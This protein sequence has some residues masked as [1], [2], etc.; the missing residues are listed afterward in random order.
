MR[1]ALRVDVVQPT[2][3]LLKVVAADGG[4]ERPGVENVVEE[5]SSQD[6]LLSN[7][8]YRH[9]LS[10]ALMPDSCFLELVVFD[11]TRVVKFL[12]RSD[13]LLEQ[14]HHFRVVLRMV[15]WEDLESKSLV[16]LVG[17]Q[18]HFGAETFTQ[19]LAEGKIV[20]HTCHL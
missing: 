13:F 5:F 2:E 7:V 9:L 20:N 17:C 19:F 3:H 12:R 11:N 1:E 14:F 4:I 8:C 16:I 6:W 10:R 15:Q 18:L